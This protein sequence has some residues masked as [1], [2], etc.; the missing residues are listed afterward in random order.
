[1]KHIGRKKYLYFYPIL[2]LFAITILQIFFATPTDAADSYYDLNTTSFHSNSFAGGNGTRTNPYLISNAKE[3]ARIS[4]LYNNTTSYSGTYFKLINDIDWST[5]TTT[6]NG[7]T[8]NLY[9]TPIGKNSTYDFNG[10]IIGNNYKILNLNVGNSTNWSKNTY[11]GFIGYSNASSS[12]EDLTIFGTIYGSTYAGGFCA[13]SNSTITLENCTSWVTVY[14]GSTTYYSSTTAGGLVGYAKSATITNCINFNEVS[15]KSDDLY[16]QYAGGIVGQTSS[17]GTTKISNCFN[18]AHIV[19]TDCNYGYLGGIVGYFM[20]TSGSYI[21]AC[22]NT[23]MIDNYGNNSYS[24]GITAITNR[25]I[26]R[27]ENS[28]SVWA[29]DGES[30][31]SC[32]G[33]I[34]GYNQ[35]NSSTY[36]CLN[37]GDVYGYAKSITSSTSL[38]YTFTSEYTD[39]FYTYRSG[40]TIGKYGSYRLRNGTQ[41]WTCNWG[42]DRYNYTSLSFP[43]TKTDTYDNAYIGGIAGYTQTQINTCVNK[44]SIETNYIESQITVGIWLM[45]ETVIWN[46]N[47]EN[48]QPASSMLYTINYKSGITFGQISGNNYTQSGCYYINEN[49]SESD[50]PSYSYR[51]VGYGVSGAYNDAVITAEGSS[52]SDSGTLNN[53]N[54]Y[55]AYDLFQI[56]YNNKII[57]LKATSGSGY[58]YFKYTISQNLS[59]NGTYNSS[60]AAANISSA[61]AGSGSNLKIKDIYWETSTESFN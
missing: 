32:S 53:G 44:G 12:V 9:W 1:M 2:L 15:V 40:L 57:A 22:R 33:G 7:I 61:W 27:C 14:S 50:T 13:Y 49:P 36:N 59:H 51:L 29:G 5:A 35:T 48:Y 34:V 25:T 52:E 58:E 23:G 8:Y 41:A 20:G 30:D 37:T 60:I 10:H 11:A 21:A 39:V 28:G 56:S 3:L 42:G 4:Y 47:I 18:R 46:N 31:S 54:S 24:G 55:T 16:S 17:S 19:N 43:C 6:V 38:S 26:E 45:T